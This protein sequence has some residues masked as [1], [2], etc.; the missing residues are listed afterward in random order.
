MKAGNCYS[1]KQDKAGNRSFNSLLL[2]T[3]MYDQFDEAQAEYV[4]IHHPETSSSLFVEAC[5]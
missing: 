2:K 1:I 4:H 5:N 3:T